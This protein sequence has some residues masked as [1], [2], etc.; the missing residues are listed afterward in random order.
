ML[1]HSLLVIGLQISWMSSHS[2]TGDRPVVPLYDIVHV[3]DVRDYE[4]VENICVSNVIIALKL[5]I[6][7]Y[8]SGHFL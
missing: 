3:K 8:C 2:F 1:H 4:D 5:L 6:Y 7:N